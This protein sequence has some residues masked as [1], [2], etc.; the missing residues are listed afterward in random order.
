MKPWTDRNGRLSYLKLAAL[1][2][3]LAPGAWIAGQ[4]ATGQLGPLPIE[5]VND[6]TGRWAIRLL[7]L[8][9]LVTPV[10]RIGNWPRLILVRRMLGVA[11]LA[12]AAVHFCAF[13]LNQNLD[14]TRIVSEISQRVYLA[15]GFAGLSGLLVLG[16][17]SFDRVIRWMGYR[18]KTLHRAVYA[19]AVL[20][21]VHFFLQAKIDATEPTL[22]AGFFILLMG[23]RLAIAMRVRLS[24]LGVALTGLAASA[25][26]AAAE[27]AWYGLATGVDALAVLEANLAF[28]QSI[29]PAAVV[30]GAGIVM[31][32]IS[33][34]RSLREGKGGISVNRRLAGAARV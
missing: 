34:T 32:A 26:T 19:I 28:P 12:Y 20:G 21:I 18:W 17:T 6:V 5:A 1:A 16:A 31:T 7:L 3:A 14:L 25:A 33:A 2:G 11:T 10:Q 24:P 29:R 15:I 9:L 27:Y 30:L 4:L 8:S 23:Y 13:A 22:M